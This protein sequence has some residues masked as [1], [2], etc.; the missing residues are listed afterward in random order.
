MQDYL[1]K[2]RN[3]SEEK[4]QFT[5]SLE[6]ENEQLR[7]QVGQVIEERDAFVQENQAI[8][9]LLL[10]EGL[11]LSAETT[12]KRQVVEKL[13][14]ERMEIKQ[15]LEEIT[16]EKVEAA[17]K[18]DDTKKELRVKEEEHKS[19]LES[20]QK[21]SVD[22]SKQLQAMEETHAAE[23]LR[24]SQERDELKA[25]IEDNLG[26]LALLRVEVK[27]LKTKLATDS[28]AHEIEA[29]KLK[30][31]IESKTSGDMVMGIVVIEFLL[32]P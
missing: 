9:E 30:K 23:K 8:A 13:L 21:S 1:A 5:Q 26:K 17:K 3:L 12:P 11:Q 29:T 27:E 14:Q 7:K 10:A 4:A 31:Q 28:R 32:Q 24:L 2:I 15:Q 19:N 22:V 25:S 16:K 18:L 20:S 6:A